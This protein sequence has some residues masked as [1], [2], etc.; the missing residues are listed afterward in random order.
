[1][2][3][4]Y[5]KKWCLRKDLHRCNHPQSLAKGKKIM[6]LMNEDHMQLV[7]EGVDILNQVNDSLDPTH[8]TFELTGGDPQ[9]LELKS[10]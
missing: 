9:T 7:L 2:S 6:I 4:Q 5:I 8:K 1:M 3:N 10:F